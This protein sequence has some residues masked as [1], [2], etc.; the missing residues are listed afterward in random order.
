MFPV[1]QGEIQALFLRHEGYLG[2]VGAFVKGVEEEGKK[3][4][5]VI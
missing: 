2:A 3:K 4:T 1:F 5:D